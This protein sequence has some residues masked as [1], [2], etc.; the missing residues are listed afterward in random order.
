[1]ASTL[2]F[3][4]SLVFLGGPQHLG[5]ESA[6]DFRDISWGVGRKPPPSQ[7]LRLVGAFGMSFFSLGMGFRVKRSIS[8]WLFGGVLGFCLKPLVLVNL[9]LK[10]PSLRA[11]HYID[12]WKVFQ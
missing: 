10:E 11:E 3:H 4:W 6:A 7:E 8:K 5:C 1:M 9:Q 12:L 2:V